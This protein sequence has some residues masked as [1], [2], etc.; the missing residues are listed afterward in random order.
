MYEARTAS[1]QGNEGA[2]FCDGGNFACYNAPNFRFHT[3]TMYC[4]SLPRFILLVPPHTGGF[5]KR[6]VQG[7]DIFVPA[8]RHRSI[9]DII[10]YF[11]TGGDQTKLIP[12]DLF[13]LF[14]R[15][16]VRDV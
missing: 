4:F 10:K 9:A 5:Q 3:H 11:I 7:R 6:P 12:G 14:L 2:K 15:A 8:M 16:T 1:L 13:H